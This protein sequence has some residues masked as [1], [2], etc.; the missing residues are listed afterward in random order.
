M[1]LNTARPPPAGSARKDL[2][3]TS[4]LAI[5]GMLVALVAT[6]PPCA[7]GS[8]T[9]TGGG[10]LV[11]S[12]C[13]CPTPAVCVGSR[14]SH[15]VDETGNT[16]MSGWVAA[17]CSDCTC[18]SGIAAAAG[19]A[20]EGEPT[21]TNFRS[22]APTVTASGELKCG[23]LWFLHIPKTGG[24]TT[25]KYLYTRTRPALPG[26]RWLMADLYSYPHCHPALA[27]TSMDGWGAAPVWADALVELA[28]PE[29]RL[30]VHQHH[31]SPGLVGLIP[32]L[33]QLNATLRAKGCGLYLATIV[34][35]PV[36]LA[37]SRAH[38]VKTT[39]AQYEAIH[40]TRSRGVCPQET[41]SV[42]TVSLYMRFGGVNLYS[43][44]NN[45]ANRCSEVT[46]ERLLQVKAA[47]ELF[48]LVYTTAT[49][50][51][52]LSRLSTL[53]GD[54]TPLRNVPHMHSNI[55][56]AFELTEADKHDIATLTAA[57]RMLYNRFAGVD[58]L[59]PQHA[60]TAAP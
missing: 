30:V 55:S 27:N 22:R 14:C 60:N 33:Q 17:L 48:D 25:E 24:S 1:A 45:I 2:A 23:V 51:P 3:S 21:P 50:G 5:A 49:L 38:F 16:T 57:D 28:R 53:T 6:L 44:P 47:L 42:N 29:P 40:R 58:R 46:F 4:A 26:R 36:L 9:C 12:H 15:A 35:D 52:F 8:A 11:G 19:T 10:A 7:A 41:W 13:V 20:S 34:R 56:H 43:S 18:G 39:V 32:Q 59:L 54:T 37:E 31:C